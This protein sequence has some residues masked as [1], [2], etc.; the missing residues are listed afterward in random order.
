MWPEALFLTLWNW[1]LLT[2]HV[3]NVFLCFRLVL[4]AWA[5]HLIIIVKYIHVNFRFYLFLS[6]S[7]CFL[8]AFCQ[9]LSNYQ[10]HTC[11]AI[12]LCYC[13]VSIKCGIT[14]KQHYQ[15]MVKW[16]L[17]FAILTIVLYVKWYHLSFKVLIRERF[18]LCL[19]VLL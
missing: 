3:Q 16:V 2:Q 14:R 8:S 1:K 4:T 6:P 15:L 12:Q 7:C 10:V 17:F 11:H 9:L 13:V 5:Y 19:Q 18:H